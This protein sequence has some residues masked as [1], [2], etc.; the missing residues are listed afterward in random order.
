MGEQEYEL[1]PLY[2]FLTIFNDG[3]RS[4][5]RV[6]SMS[7]AKRHLAFLNDF[8]KIKG[9]VT[10]GKTLEDSEFIFGSEE[11]YDSVLQQEEENS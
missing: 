3:Y 10:V 6:P 4:T 7:E 2:L 1:E 8:Y 5:I 9:Y 11:Y